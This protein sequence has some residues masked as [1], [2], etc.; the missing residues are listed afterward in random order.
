MAAT[1]GGAAALAAVRPTVAPSKSRVP[2]AVATGALRMQMF[3]FALRWRPPAASSGT[4]DQQPAT[5][6]RPQRD[7]VAQALRR[8]TVMLPLPARRSCED[9]SGARL[10]HLLPLHAL[11]ARPAPQAQPRGR[12]ERDADDDLVRG[13]VA[14]PPDRGALGV[15]LKQCLHELI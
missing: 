14:M 2:S 13:R 4:V 11:L 12:E 7:R 1:F 3:S 5:A 6:Q 10:Q 15:A 9:V 8:R